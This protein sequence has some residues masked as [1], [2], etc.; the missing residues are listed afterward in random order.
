MKNQREEIL[1]IMK[2]SGIIDASFCAFLPLLPYLIDC[3]AKDRLPENSKTVITCFFPY[4]VKEKPPKN[5]S[6]YAAVPDY[7]KVLEPF[8]S[9]ATENLRSYFPNNKFEYFMDNSPIPE[10]RAAALSG[11]GVI[12]DN[13][14]LITEKYGS[15]VFLGEIV[16]DLFVETKNEIKECIHCKECEKHCPKSHLGKCLSAITQQK[17]DLTEK[18]ILAIKS[19]NCL[20]GCDLCAEYCPLNAHAEITYIKP[21]LKGYRDEYVFG[22]NITGRAY[23]W[24]GEKV[25]L[26]N[27]KL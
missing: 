23:A 15:F 22:E 25:I 26:R 21:F 3:R 14:L 7:H 20:W 5:I 12:G 4:K 24:R 6:R 13:G 10:V 11:L 9:L 17:A 16:T 19:N 1:S 2:K 18:E 8:L 27:S